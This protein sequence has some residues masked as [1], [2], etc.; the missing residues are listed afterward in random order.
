MA[1]ERS[2]GGIVLAWI[3]GALLKVNGED[4]E[5]VPLVFLLARPPEEVDELEELQA[6]LFAIPIIAND[7]VKKIELLIVGYCVPSMREQRR[8]SP[9]LQGVALFGIEKRADGLSAMAG[10]KGQVKV[11]E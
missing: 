11:I 8:H 10:G 1:V 4:V 9:G 5:P 3:G 6:V 2:D 7:R